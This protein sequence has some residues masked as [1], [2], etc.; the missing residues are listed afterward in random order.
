M[1]LT[2]IILAGGTMLLLS[3]VAGYLLG[4]A[5]KKLAIKVDPKVQAALACLPGANCGGCGYV[6]CGEYAA[7]CAAGEAVTKCTVGGPAVAA[8]LGKAMGV[9]VQQT[10]PYRPAVHCSADVDARLKRRP[11]RGV[12]TCAAANLV[13]GIQGCT[14][15]CLGLGDC[16]GACKYGA[17]RIVKGLAQVDYDA[18]TGCGACAKACP[19]AV[20]SMVPFKAEQMVV[21]ACSNKDPGRNTREVCTVGCLGCGACA[22][23]N[24]LFKVTDNL[25]RVDYDRYDATRDFGPAMAKC[26]RKIIVYIGK[27][28]QKDLAAVADEALPDQ[29]E[30]NFETTVDKTDFRG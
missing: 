8:A 15:G 23:L 21:V 5:D 19:R 14:Y 11:Y 17:V 16:F 18:C 26:P 28:S 6:G 24:D 25:S 2:L 22:K 27:P 12:P 30:A 3:V 9:D 29:V 20:I 1:L 7:A 10:W 13:G 4:L